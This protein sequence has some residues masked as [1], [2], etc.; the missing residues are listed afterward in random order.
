M[1]CWN[2]CFD[3]LL[4]PTQLLLLDCG[5]GAVWEAG[6]KSD[7]ELLDPAQMARRL[8][9]ANHEGAGR[10]AK[11]LS[12]LA[13]TIRQVS[14]V[15]KFVEDDPTKTGLPRGGRGPG[16]HSRAGARSFEAAVGNG[17]R[18]PVRRRRVGVGG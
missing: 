4:D 3:R 14:K 18:R 1:T 16:H 15:M 7:M 8:S 17:D 6:A 10:P 9:A 5:G 11:W 13:G 12:V 2:V